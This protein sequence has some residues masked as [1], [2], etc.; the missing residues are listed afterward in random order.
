MSDG[1][2][3]AFI[4]DELTCHSLINSNR[5]TAAELCLIPVGNRRNIEQDMHSGHLTSAEYASTLAACLDNDNYLIVTDDTGTSCQSSTMNVS[6]SEQASKPSKLAG[7]ISEDYLIIIGRSPS[8]FS[9][10]AGDNVLTP[11]DNPN[12]LSNSAQYEPLVVAADATSQVYIDVVDDSKHCSVI[13][14]ARNYTSLQ[15]VHEQ[16]QEQVA[17]D[18]NYDNTTEIFDVSEYDNNAELNVSAINV[19]MLLITI[20]SRFFE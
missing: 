5:Q 15:D 7:N 14:E 16:Q 1:D 18:P 10:S 20:S 9:A 4:N 12:K 6:S 3:C 2:N 17:R 11:A 8:N 19:S 13:S